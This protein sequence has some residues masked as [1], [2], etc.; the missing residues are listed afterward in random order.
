[1]HFHPRRTHVAGFT[2]LEVVFALLLL[3]VCLIPAANALRAAVG[4]PGVTTL[5]A[6]NLDCVSSLMEQVMAEPYVR[7][8]GYATASG[9]SAYPVP[10]DAGCPARQVTIQRYG[11]DATKLIGP[12]GTGDY[13]LYISVALAD[14][15]D[16]NPFTFRT[17]VAR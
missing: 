6:R 13:L 14:P 9:V 3:G 7:L 5:A 4:T 16:G 15:A 1:M 8:L 17:L 12:G 11:N 10:T 2:L